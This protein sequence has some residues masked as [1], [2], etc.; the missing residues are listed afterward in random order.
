MKKTTSSAAPII[1]TL[2]S[3]A[4]AAGTSA[5]DHGFSAGAA[6]VKE[7]EKYAPTQVSSSD[8]LVN[9]PLGQDKADEI[10]SA[11]GLIKSLCL[12]T[13][14]CT[15]LISGNSQDGSVNPA[16]AKLMVACLAS[17]TNTTVNPCICDI[18]GK[19]T[20][21]VLGSYGLTVDGYG[22]LQSLANS[23]QPTRQINEVLTPGGYLRKWAKA[24]GA[25]QSLDMLDKSAYTRQLPHGIAAQ[26]EGTDAQLALY[27]NGGQSAVVGV[28]MVPS[29]WEINFCLLYV[30]NPAV[31]AAMPAYWTA[32]PPNVVEALENS[33]LEARGTD[34]VYIPGQISGGMVPFSDY[35]SEFNYS[36]D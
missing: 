28:S 12:T 21:I 11:L 13:D 22:L 32:I 35:A 23:N 36:P 8:P 24:N 20:E 34:F 33:A 25:E 17:F 9:Q 18:N 3:K 7:L 30:L 5:Q 14:Q 15:T 10:A 6:G 19:R 29:I 26:H 1:E 4:K 16:Y 27:L 2:I 31:A